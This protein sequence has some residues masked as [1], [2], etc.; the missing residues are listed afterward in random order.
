MQIDD[1]T[2]APA[3]RSTS[4]PQIASL[5]CAPM[6][7]PENMNLARE[8]FVSALA[9][10]ERKNYLAAEASLRRAL[11]LVP[12][13]PSILVNYMGVLVALQRFVDA[14]PI[15]QKVTALQP[16]SAEAWLN[17]GLA[18]EGCAQPEAAITALLRT[19]ELDPQSAPAL[20]ALGRIHRQQGH[21]QE[22]VACLHRAF[23]INR[24]EPGVC[25]NLANALTDLN[26]AQAAI[27]C[28]R[29]ALQQTPD[30]PQVQTNLAFAELLAGDYA[31]GWRHY[32]A[33]FRAY[34]AEHS[35]LMTGQPWHGEQDVSGKRVLLYAE[36]G[37]GDVLQFCRYAKKVKEL[38]AYVILAVQPALIPLLHTLEGVDE[39]CSYR[40]GEEAGLPLHDYHSPLLRLPLVFK[41]RLE[42]IPNQ[43]P[44]L[45]VP[46]RYRQKWQQ[47]LPAH[48][49]LK[50]GIAWSGFAGQ[51]NDHNRSMPLSC[52]TELF[53]L[54]ADFYV[55]QTNIRPADRPVLDAYSNVHDLS[56]KIEDFADTAAIVE[57]L[58]VVVS[59]CTSIAHLAGAMGKPLGVML[60]YAAD[61]RWLLQREDSPWYPSARLFRQSAP[62]DWA[63]VVGQVREHIQTK[64]NKIKAS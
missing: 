44:Y 13:R 39:L 6:S 27:P 54:D 16:D 5:M 33:R 31:S 57:Q 21:P 7:L 10:I 63:G 2:A 48:G 41:T 36:Q 1:L 64:C 12:D 46:E 25:N 18:Y 19:V 3:I 28:Y 53:A 45:R 62:Q 42:N 8:L 38:G 52:L 32:E 30:D 17:L 47:A 23:D 34:N 37:F 15:G 43:V 20:A 29:L 61:W 58:D 49:R 50:I 56:S 11:E 26:D 51:K 22:A 35:H 40:V 59:V 14:V 60:C 4:P 55:L 9:E 24:A